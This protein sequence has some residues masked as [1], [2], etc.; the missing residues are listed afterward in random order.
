[1]DGSVRWV[2]G[3][4]KVLHD[5]SGKP[6]RMVGLNADIT[7]WKQAEQ[8]L[9][10]SAERNRAILRA[11]PD[12]VFLFDRNGVFLDYHA[13]DTSALLVAPEKFLGKSVRDILPPTVAENVMY[14]LGQTQFSDEPQV[15]DYSLIIE[16][17]ER[18]YEARLIGLEGDRVLSIVRDVTAG[19]KASEALTR[20]E[21]N[22]RQSN[23]QISALAGQLITAQELERRRISRQLHDD[24]SQKIATLSVTISRL[25]RSLTPSEE[26]LRTELDQLGRHTTD[27]TT[28]IRRLSHQL[29]PAVLEHLGLVSALESYISEFQDQEEIEVR[30]STLIGNDKIPLDVSVCLYRVAVEALRNIARHSGSKVAAISLERNDGFLKLGISDSGIGFDVRAGIRGHGL[31]LIGA[32]ERVKLLNGVFEIQS[33]PTIGTTVKASIPLPK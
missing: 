1:P 11:L 17:E 26:H 27:L 30:M 4:G 32:E 10:E 6:A 3:K 14:C 12:L 8:A 15:L 25:K 20:S 22:L 16:G 24:L 29:H 9:H 13:R 7:Q 18:H 19:R 5:D 2:R 33:V 31:G 21:E 23:R 28:D